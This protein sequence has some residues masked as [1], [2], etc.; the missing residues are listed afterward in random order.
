[1]FWIKK[2]G[3]GGKGQLNFI[4]LFTVIIVLITHQTLLPHGADYLIYRN[5]IQIIKHY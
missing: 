1:M 5:G 2:E 3:E 4:G